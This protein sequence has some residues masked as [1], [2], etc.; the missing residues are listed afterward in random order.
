MASFWLQNLVAYSL[1][2]AT[3]AAAGAV[4]LR[5][6]RIRVPNIRVFCGQALIVACLLLPAIQP[7]L[8]GKI[9]SATVRVS[10]G[11]GTVVESRQRSNS[12]PFPITT[13]VL[14]LV[15]TGILVRAGMLGLGCWRVR[16][17]RRTSTIM[18]GAFENL[19]RRLGAVADFRV[20]SDVPGPV[21]FGFL[22]PVIF[23]PESCVLNESIACHE[24]VHVRRRDWLFT[25]AEECI[26]S[27]FWFHP[28][29]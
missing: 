24:L 19:Q 9:S 5:L 21:T 1:Q 25:V 26:L 20:S 10:T 18:P 29:M 6:L 3:L 11:P 22:R 12:M 15:G 23:L 13:V 28:A 27:V 8:P 16:R 2:I 7:R 14:F 4:L 17:Y